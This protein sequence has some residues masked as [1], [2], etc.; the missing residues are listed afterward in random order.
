MDG[1]KFAILPF[2]SF[3]S[4][5]LFYS[6]V[7]NVFLTMKYDFI[8]YGIAYYLSWFLSILC[9]VL[10]ITR[11]REKLWNFWKTIPLYVHYLICVA[12][13]TMLFIIIKHILPSLVK[14]EYE[15]N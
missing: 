13:F 3:L 14:K 8:S 11:L 6:F 1:H 10:E 4:M 5:V 12:Y 9:I 15:K 7:L 2:L